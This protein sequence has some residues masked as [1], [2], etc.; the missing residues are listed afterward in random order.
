M[1]SAAKDARTMSQ[2]LFIVLDGLDGT[3][4]STQC[5]LLAEWL[6]AQG[7]VVQICTD[8]GGTEVGKV[9]RALLLEHKNAL[10]LP[11]EALLFMASR[12]QLVDEVI[13]PAL[14]QGNVIICDRF[15][16]A[17][18]VYQGHAGGLD[19]RLLWEIGHMVTGGLEPDLTLVLDLPPQVASARLTGPRDRLESRPLDYQQRVRE[20]F[21]I[22]ALAHPDSMRILD[23]TGS[24]EKVQAAVRHEVLAYLENAK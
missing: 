19:P 4:K 7:R 1:S 6:R 24:I 17:N 9:L 21:R 5:R 23:A 11:C 10:T 3:G 8:P 18:V 2:A 15:L 16:L 22:E 20:G 12:A 13:R 14:T